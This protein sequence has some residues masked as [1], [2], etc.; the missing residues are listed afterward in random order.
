MFLGLWWNDLWLA[1]RGA[2]RR[3]GFTLLVA[4]TLALGIGVNSAVFA[5]LDGVLLRPL[6]YRD[7]ARVVFLWQTFLSQ[8][9]LELEPTAF[10][11]NAWHA[12]RG[13]SELA[14]VRSDTFTLTGGDNPERVR[15]SRM[16]ASLM[17]LLGIAPRLGRNFTAAEDFD[18]TAG[19]AILSDGLWR[20]RFGAD[21][22]VLGRIIQIDGESRTIVGVMPRGVSLPRPLAGDDDL[23][24]PARLSAAD[25]VSAVFHSQ[26]ILGRLA[27]GVSLEQASAELEAFAARMAAERPTHKQLGGRIVPVAE[28][29]VRAIRPALLL[30]GGCVALLLLVA[31]ANAPPLLPARASNRRHET[32]IRSA[33][34]ATRARLLSIAISESLVFAALGGVAGLFLGAAALRAVLPLFAGAL[35]PAVPIDVDSR[36]AL[37]T[38]AT[39][40]L[41]AILFGIIVGLHGPGGRLVDQLKASS[42]TIAGS[43]AR[44]RNALVVAQV[45]LAVLLLSAAGLMLT[46]VVKLSHVRPG[47]DA[48]HLLTFRVALSGSNYTAAPAR[49][50]FTDDILARL[51]ATPGVRRAALSS[52]IPFGGQRGANG[53]EIEGRPPAPGQTLIA[54]QR[55]IS[56]GYFQT[57]NIPIVQ[58]RAFQPTDDARAEPVAI[59]NRAMAKRFWPNESPIDRRIRT[60]AGFDS[61]GWFRIVGVVDDVRHVS[62]SRDAV[63]EMYR[64][65]AQTGMPIFTVVVR[66]DGEPA[67]LAAATRAA[68]QAIDPDLPIYDVRTMEDRIAASFAQTR[69]TMLLLVVTAALASALSAIAIYG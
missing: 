67:A 69:G 34:G 5:L 29:T 27:A 24:M 58:G 7:P 31:S 40:I 44:A 16:T 39:S 41:L 57:M 8:N 38:A 12:L 13:V 66:S 42:R 36:V 21:D 53:F 23:W 11:Y 4:V 51:E 65:I 6:P 22:R 61:G 64:P 1:C 45:A 63:T 30:I 62:L 49:V 20:R 26:K 10:D 55:H 35:P 18:G 37:F 17:P 68:V 33:L 28:Q 56:P 43:A 15:G 25:R 2:A 59:V 50:A 3:P 52:I 32:A 47:F 14:M 60:T 46:S 9:V 48:S 19:V 54:D